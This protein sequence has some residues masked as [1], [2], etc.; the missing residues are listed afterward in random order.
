MKNNT[1]IDYSKIKIETKKK[2]NSENKFDYI[3]NSGGKKTSIKLTPGMYI[4]AVCEV[5][6]ID[7]IITLETKELKCSF[8]ECPLNNVTKV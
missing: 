8:C 4:K 6:G 2:E 7:N 3:I 1:D 5:C